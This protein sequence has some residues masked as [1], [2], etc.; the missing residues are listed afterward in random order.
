MGTLELALERQEDMLN[1]ENYRK[2][3][4]WQILCVD[5][6]GCRLVGQREEGPVP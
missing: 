2:V 5:N 6:R 1:E 4:R 3:Q